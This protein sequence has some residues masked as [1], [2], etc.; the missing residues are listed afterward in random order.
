M[1][2]RYV[3]LSLSFS[4]IF[5]FAFSTIG[6]AQNVINTNGDFSDASEGQTS[7]I[8]SWILEGTEYADFEV[9]QDPEDDTNLVLRVT[10]ND[11]EG[12]D[13]WNVQAMN[14]DTQFSA[15]NDYQISFRVR[16]DQD[17]TVQLDA[18]SGAQLWGQAITGDEWHTL[19][20]DMFSPD[21]D[22]TRLV[23]VHFA[24]EDN[25]N[26]D[27]FYID[28]IEVREYE[29]DGGDNGSDTE[30]VNVNGD[31]SDAEEGQTSDITNWV[32]EGSDLA[33]YEVIAD[34][35]D[36]ENNLLQATI[37]DIEGADNPWDIQP[38]HTDIELEENEEYI[39]SAR[40]K[41][42]NA[43]GG[44]AGTVSVDAEGDLPAVYGQDISSGDWEMV[45]LAPFTADENQTIHVGVHLG[46]ETHANGDILYIDYLRV[47]KVVDDNGQVN[48][49]STEDIVWN[50]DN[51][52]DLDSW[53]NGENSAQTLQASDDNT[54]GEAAL[55]WTYTVDP[56]ESWGG[57]ADIEL[58]VEGENL[59]DLT[60]YDALS[61]DYKVLDPVTPDDG[62]ATFNMKIYVESGENGEEL[63]QWHYTVPEVLSDE[64]GEW[65]T[66]DILLE[67][68]AIPDWETTHDGELYPDRIHKI[69]MQVIVGSDG[70]EV[71][72]EI[73]LDNLAPQTGPLPIPEPPYAVGD[74]VNY[75][76]S[77]QFSDLGE[78]EPVAWVISS[79][80]GSSVEIIDDASDDDERAL[81]FTVSWNETTNWYENEA[82]NAPMNVVEGETY[83][84]SVWLKADEDG[85]I[86]RFYAS[87]P[88][89]GGYER[90]RGWDTP[91][92]TL[93]T[94]WERHD[95]TYT[96]T[97]AQEENGM[98]L[99]VEINSEENDGG[100]IYID[101]IVLEKEEATSNE[102]GEQPLSFSLEQN[103]PNP[104]NPTTTIS[105]TLPEAVDVRLDVFNVLGQRVMTLVNET[106][107]AGVKQVSF[108]ASNLASGVYMY[109][110][111]T[112]N[113]VQSRRMTLIK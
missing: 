97:A 65:Q 93:S 40:V 10:L 6:N 41:Y 15:D 19:E 14:S 84:A 104:F 108:D 98:R 67:D 78:T 22:E 61:L 75:N 82:V 31:F 39:I 28:D 58:M 45:E 88:A 24:H 76:G 9:V 103:Y 3:S 11:I 79:T 68:F 71:S 95:F 89:S 47:E 60:E 110:I 94:E 101:D 55:Q 27:V 51:P 77:F 57:S 49:P 43:G 73:L 17:G 16:G 92:T 109:R 63:E 83:R 87:M 35:D 91:E 64:S 59:T 30:I 4:L 105:Y 107:S 50:F 52:D 33:D 70:S 23:A 102:P 29:G 85:R 66:A 72:G 26:G 112:D 20:T 90:A 86:A 8:T 12:I 2:K 37:T 113:F 5:L 13:A 106:Q 46:A 36:A 53:V 1:N 21:S 48:P 18:Q 44:T 81:A 25:E 56:T 74:T 100:T 96:A 38:L 54:E 32:L 34:P 80:E 7:D 69:E 99:G 62:G 42:E 111:Q